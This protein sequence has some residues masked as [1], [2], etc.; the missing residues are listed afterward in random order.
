MLKTLPVGISTLSEICNRNCVYVDK[1]KFVKQ[2]VETGKYYFLSRPRR[3]GK[4]LF[5]DTL[6]QAFLGNKELFNGLYLES[7]WDWNTK[8]P[9]IHI[10]F[11]SGELESKEKLSEKI[12]DLINE[13]ASNYEVM[14]DTKSISSRFKE[15][16]IELYKKY[17]Q[18]VV[19]LIDEYDKPILDNISDIESSNHIRSGLRD[20]Y[21]V[22][23]DCDEYLKFVFLTGIS[24]F[25]KT[26]IFSTLNNLNDITLNSNYAD[27]CGY[28]QNEIDTVFRDYLLDVDKDELK[29]W[30]NGYNFFGQESQKVY[31]PFGILL[32][33]SN[34]KRF[35]NY[36]FSNSTPL[37]LIKLFKKFKYTLPNCESITVSPSILD[38]FDPENLNIETLLFQTGYLT[39]KDVTT[40]PFSK[41][42]EYKLGYPN[43]EVRTSLSIDVFT[44]ITL[45]AGMGGAT[46]NNLVKA[47]INN[48]YELM[49][50][51][52][53][54]FFASIPYDWYTNNDIQNYEGFYA[55]VIYS[56]FNAMGLIAIPEE[57]TNHGQIDLT[58]ELPEKVIIFEFKIQEHY[59]LGPLEQIKQ[60][61]YHEKYLGAKKPIYL[62]GMV[63]SKKARNVVD[64]AYEEILP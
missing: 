5:L 55:T 53:S 29:L 48:D 21:S 62:I 54:S 28:T 6:K 33:L 42:S 26:G 12:H 25:I 22:I 13:I 30:Y 50:Q 37:Y 51:T 11:A 27:I 23:K 1:S 17:N 61:K 24:R 32:F 3:F 60:K 47:I 19:V 38:S 18:Q 52:F 20:L 35:S 10:S 49:H 41:F 14:L 45:D 7:N 34:N 64:F 8:Y 36:W 31:N 57:P 59:S 43:F 15:L 40:N 39:I 56:C 46:K 4:S 63:F 2:L 9:V 44:S 58:I 16:I